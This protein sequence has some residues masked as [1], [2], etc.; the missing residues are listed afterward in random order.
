MATVVVLDPATPQDVTVTYPTVA[1][2]ETTSISP[3]SAAAQAALDAQEDRDAVEEIRDDMASTTGLAYREFTDQT[4]APANT[5]GDNLRLYFLDDEARVVAPTS[6]LGAPFIIP[7]WYSGNITVSPSDP[8]ERI[9]KRHAGDGV[10]TLQDGT[11]TASAVL[12][13]FYSNNLDIRA[14]N[15]GGAEIVANW[16]FENKK[17]DLLYMDLTPKDD[18]TAWL[19]QQG[20]YIGL[21]DTQTDMSTHATQKGTLGQIVDG[22]FHVTAQL[23]DCTFYV[24]DN[25]T[26]QIFDIDSGASIKFVGYDPATLVKLD[27]TGTDCQYALILDAS[28]G[29]LTGTHITGPGKAVTTGNAIALRRCSTLTFANDILIK[30]FYHGVR[31]IGGGRAYMLDGA[32]ENCTYAFRRDSGF[33][34]YVTADTTFT[35]VDNVDRSD[36]SAVSYAGAVPG[37]QLINMNSGG[38]TVAGGTTTYLGNGYNSGT[39]TEVRWRAPCDGYV[40]NLYQSATGSAGAG[41]NF[42]YTVRKNGAD[43]TV[44]AT[45]ADGV[46]TPDTTHTATFSTGDYLTIKLVT[47]AGASS[48]VHSVSVLFVT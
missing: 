27:Y 20:G 11:Y 4:A 41:K 28:G 17:V 9:I 43:T 22:H 47:D 8:W 44:V 34:E 29:L 45:T 30:D 3:T 19:V 2:G 21:R 16:A 46:L 36:A 39:E 40:K 14:A 31:I 26:S 32:F 35:S 23:R 1:G 25:L 15:L 38:A 48:R 12:T 18:S 24:G 5:T 7:T 42:T 6:T 33:I 10:I 37:Y 13:G